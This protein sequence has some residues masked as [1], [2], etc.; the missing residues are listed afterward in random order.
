MATAG[1]GRRMLLIV[2]GAIVV[3]CAG[4]RPAPTAAAR[5]GIFEELAR[6]G[7]TV[8]DVV[9]GDTG[10][11]DRALAENAVRFRLR[12]PGAASA[13]TVH[14]FAFKD[15]PAFERAAGGVDACQHVFEARSARAGGPVGRVD[16]SPYR[17]FG[18]GWDV[19]QVSFLETTM[20]AVAGD[21]GVPRGRD[22]RPLPTGAPAT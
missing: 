2:V 15:R 7:A 18:D 11:E 22:G 6:R 21:G 13:G 20:R 10:C 9:A 14:L 4:E 16:V 3:A 8:S 12:V 19:D 5:E 17:A 1:A